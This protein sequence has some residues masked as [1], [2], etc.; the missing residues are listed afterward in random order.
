MKKT[1]YCFHGTTLENAKK[2]ARNGWDWMTTD[3]PDTN[4]NCSSPNQ[5]Y[6]WCGIWVA[7]ADCRVNNL[8]EYT[9][10]DEETGNQTAI[11]WA[12][13]SAQIAAAIQ[14]FQGNILIVLGYKEEY[15]YEDPNEEFEEI[16]ITGPWSYDCSCEN[17][18][19]AMQLYAKDLNGRVPEKI[20]ICKG[21]NPMLKGVLLPIR[22]DYF[23]VE[24][25]SDLEMKIACSMYNNEE[26]FE[27]VQELISP[28]NWE[29][30]TVEKL[31]QIKK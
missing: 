22:S 5:I 16:N 4:W 23:P 2:L 11:I 3:R 25:L 1:T 10:D 8:D 14:N 24:R 28:W 18:E 20:I 31:L 13:E 19:G 12:F 17:M 21:Y 29:E 26:F 9:E 15:E 6:A 27:M 30:I 7:R